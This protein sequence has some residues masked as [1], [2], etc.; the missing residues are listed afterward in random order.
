MHGDN[1]LYDATTRGSGVQ[2]PFTDC[3]QY[4][5][6]L[7]EEVVLWP[8]KIGNR[9]L[10]N[11]PAIAA[12]LATDGLDWTSDQRKKGVNSANAE[13]RR[14]G[15]RGKIGAHKPTDADKHA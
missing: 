5:P 4:L 7:I 11:A 2:H 12:L 9:T 6:Q 10:K 1:L 8:L 3:E 14:I 15:V 13:L